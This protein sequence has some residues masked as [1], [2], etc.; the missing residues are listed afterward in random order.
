MPS[1][2]P[3]P[4]S[5]T[6]G[7]I[8]IVLLPALGIVLAGAITGFLA[9]VSVQLARPWTGAGLRPPER[10]YAPLRRLRVH[11][12]GSVLGTAAVFALEVPS[13]WVGLDGSTTGDL[14]RVVA[15]GIL[16]GVAL[17][18]VFFGDVAAQ[19]RRASRSSYGVFAAVWTAS[20]A[21]YFVV[22]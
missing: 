9:A 16:L 18:R 19:Q 11:V 17:H 12:V 14:L 21:M 15:V 2:T 7:P 20:T 22:V 5:S 3:D 10:G 6:P 8:E 4:G 1:P 13:A